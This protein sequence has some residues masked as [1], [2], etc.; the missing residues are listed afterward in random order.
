MKLI[1]LQPEWLIPGKVFIFMSPSGHKDWLL[2]KNIPMSMKEQFALFQDEYLR[3]KGRTVVPMKEDV[4]WNIEGNFEDLT[5]TPSIDA[6]A[7]GNWHGWI[8]KG[9]IK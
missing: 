6:S 4:C 7:S 1:E 3:Y 9:E 5:V 8:T 2:C